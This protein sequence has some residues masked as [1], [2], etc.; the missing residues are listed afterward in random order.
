MLINANEPL[1]FPM[2]RYR[3]DDERLK[4]YHDNKPFLT[5]HKKNKEAFKTEIL[6]YTKKCICLITMWYIKNDKFEPEIVEKV[7]ILF[8]SIRH[9]QDTIHLL[10]TS[11]IA[12]NIKITKEKIVSRECKTI[13]DL[14][15]G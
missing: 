12:G 1:S 5:P 2:R 14:Y 7:V 11:I 10:M 8:I 15:Y 13:L 4:T 6:I 3:N 9:E